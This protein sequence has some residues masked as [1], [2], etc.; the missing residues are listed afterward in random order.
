MSN[1]TSSKTHASWE[2]DREAWLK[3]EAVQKIE[4]KDK[5]GTVTTTEYIERGPRYIAW[6]RLREQQRRER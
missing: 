2:A 5:H 3:R 1:Q 6:K 4:F